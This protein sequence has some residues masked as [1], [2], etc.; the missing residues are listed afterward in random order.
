M[1]SAK[2]AAIAILAAGRGSRL[3]G[4]RPKP[5]TLWQGMPLVH[6]ALA[7]ALASGVGPVVVVVGYGAEQVMPLVAAGVHVVIN[8]HWQT[9]L[10][11]SLK[12]ALVAIEPIAEVTGLCVGLAD[13]PLIGPDAYRYLIAAAHR[14]LDLAVATYAG[15]R[16]NPVYLGRS[17]WAQA[18]QLEGDT[19][20]R[21]LM[22]IHPVTDVPCDGTGHPLDVDTPADL[23]HL[24]RAHRSQAHRSK[25]SSE[26]NSEYGSPLPIPGGLIQTAS[27][28]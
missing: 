12:A 11:S 20:A 26:H 16:R 1:N 13:Q 8:P 28:A 4:D 9:G 21:Q 10:A 24:A 2:T 22:A 7:A 23:V 17:L 6:H 3:G 5:L 25:Y 27:T 14:G 18:M 15:Q 19:G